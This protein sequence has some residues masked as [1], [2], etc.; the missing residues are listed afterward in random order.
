[1]NGL[2]REEGCD[3]GNLGSWIPE[4]WHIAHSQSHG[5]QVVH[6]K[7]NIKILDKED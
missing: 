6:T 5:L 2:G 3:L 7:A 1:M 4:S